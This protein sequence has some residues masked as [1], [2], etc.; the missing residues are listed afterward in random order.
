M[1][2]P[3]V[4][5]SVWDPRMDELGARYPSAVMSLVAPDG[6]PFSLR[7]P[8]TVDPARHRVRI[9]TGVLGLPVQ[10]GLVCLTAHDHHPQFVWQRNFQ[11]R[12]D[13]V[14]EGDGWSVIPHRLVGGLEL[15]P[16]SAF[17]RYR[18]NLGRIV[19]FHRRA[20]QELRARR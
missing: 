12:G 16:G 15:P 4:G 10:S 2:H 6:F 5:A 20:R 18:G 14:Q 17:Q 13:L 11:V 3:R 8:I 9:G 7:V 1:P 19:R